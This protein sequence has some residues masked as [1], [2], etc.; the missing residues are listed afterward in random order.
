MSGRTLLRYG[1]TALCAA[2][3]LALSGAAPRSQAAPPA[4]AVPAEEYAVYAAAMQKVLRAVSF[5]VL[6]RTST[7]GTPSGIPAAP[8]FPIED[9][10]RLTSDLVGDFRAK[11]TRSS[12]LADGFPTAVSVSLLTE[13]ENR[14]MFDGCAGGDACG[15]TAF[16]KRY[17]G[18]SGVTTLSRV[19]F[20]EAHD[21]A[22]LYLSASRD[23]G[24]PMGLSLLLAKYEGRWEVI[25]M[26]VNRLA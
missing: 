7:F 10:A 22:L 4:A 19:G 14:A 25:G 20:N 21:I 26:A 23:Y 11:N 13:A 6:D 15:W 1:T 24:P 12:R 8:E 18:V 5:V 17:P 9:K 16:H 3:G 2:V